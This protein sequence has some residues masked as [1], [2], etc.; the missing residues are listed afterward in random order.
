MR[1]FYLIIIALATV[2]TFLSCRKDPLVNMQTITLSKENI[3]EEPKSVTIVGTFSYPGTI[4]SV[5]VCAADNEYLFNLETYPTVM[6]GKNFTATLTG[7]QPATTYYYYYAVYYGAA[8][9]F[10]TEIRNFKTTDFKLPEVITAV[11]SFVGSDNAICGGEVTDDGGSTVS[12]RGVCYGQQPEP[13]LEGNHTIDSCGTGAFVSNITGLLKNTKYY[14]RAYATN[15]KGTSYGIDMEFT[16]S[17]LSPTVKTI[18]VTDIDTISARISCEVVSDGGSEL[19]ERGVC[20]SIHQNPTLEDE[21]LVV[22]NGVGLFTANVTGLNPSTKYYIRAYAK[23]GSGLGFGEVLEFTTA[24][25]VTYPTVSTVEIKN[26]TALTATAVGNVSSDGGAEITSRGFCWSKTA[27]PTIQNAHVEVSGTT[28]VFESSLTGLEANTTYHVRAYA[29]N[30]KGAGYGEELTFTTTEGLPVVVTSSVTEITATSAKCGGNVTDQGASNVTERGICWSTNHNPTIADSHASGGSGTGTYTCSMTGLTPNATY[31]VRAYAKNTQGISYGTEV[32][33][34][35]LEGLPT[36]TTSAVTSITSTTATGGGNV[37]NQGASNVTERGICWGTEH[38]PAMSGSHASS[39]SGAGQF[40]AQMTGLTPGTKYYVRAYAKNTQG[41]TYGME[42][43]FTTTA[44]MPTVTTGSVSEITQ[45]TATGSGNVTSDGGSSV[46]ERGICWSTDANPT[47]EMSHI[48]SGS[49]TGNFSAGMTGLTAGTT[50]HVRA[51]ATNSAGTAYG[52]DVTF[53]TTA[54]LPT[55]TT[56]QVS[57][58]TQTTAVGGGNVTS[59]GGANVTER[60]VC[61]SLNADP[62]TSDSHATSGTGTGG[63]TANMTGLT[64]NTT[65]HVRAYA[66]NSQGTSYGSDVTFTTSE[67]ISAPTVTTSAVT[68]ITQTT[69]V[70]GGNVTADGGANVTER[71]ICWGTSQNP[72]TSGTHSNSGTGIG[73]YTVQMSGLTANTTYYVRAYAVNSAG[74]S[75]GEQKSFTTLQNIVVPTVTTNNV[76]DITQTT[77]TCGGNVTA[78]GGATVTARGVCW[79]TSSNPTTSNSHTTNGSGT[80]TFTSSI[81]GLSANTTYYVRAYATNS[82]GTSYGD[83]KSFTTQS[84]GG[85]THAYVDL[86]LP[87][88][89]L[90]ATCNVGATNPEDYGSYF[91]WG[92]TSPKSNYDWST[93][94]WCN[95]SETTLTKYCTQS[96]CGYNGFVDN[97]TVLEPADDAAH[98]NWGG[99]WR[100]PTETEMEEMKNNCTWTWTTQGGKSGYMVTGSNNNSIFLPAAGFYNG[101]SLNYAGSR[102]DYWSS[103]LFMSVPSFAHFLYYYSSPPVGMHQNSRDSGRSVRPVCSPQK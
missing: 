12:A 33:F 2:L 27:N 37:T 3:T 86:G 58:I 77:A 90:W 9:P 43:E 5:R 1:K 56:S 25:I 76:T 71:G 45:T 100:M 21:H 89:T 95:G 39:G 93:Y 11:V 94:Q 61:W 14:V 75:Y 83:Q 72:T 50:Y 26:V 88:G 97:K 52:N 31:Y 28:G 16:T 68:T 13:T 64:A 41:V 92:E 91:A 23:N 18:S 40:T 34:V 47:I 35:A 42:V 81:T 57:N 70:G 85:G 84:G 87:S 62:T 59:D 7:L 99:D 32:N 29:V 46:T 60:G 24:N 54:T 53:T 69:A 10:E 49:G 66:K 17:A 79:S 4:D 38:N 78:D 20:W 8:K 48:A 65:Y 36:V 101:S 55:V 96:S 82:A 30:S 74:T 44:T 102:G 15:E 19:K 6:S 80:G 67:S 73:D 22:G 63:F 98:V 103:S 51:Y